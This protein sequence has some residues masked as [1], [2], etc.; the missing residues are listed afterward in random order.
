MAWGAAYGNAVWRLCAGLAIRIRQRGALARVKLIGEAACASG[1]AMHVPPYSG[2][3][4]ALQSQRRCSA[5]VQAFAR[6]SA[7]P[8]KVTMLRFMR[9]SSIS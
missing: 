7:C 3:T 1:Q 2:L 6:L 8:Q 4:G 9:R 5:L